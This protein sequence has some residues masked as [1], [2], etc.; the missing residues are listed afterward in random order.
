MRE[1]GM[2][3]RHIPWRRSPKASPEPLWLYLQLDESA[4]DCMRALERP[5]K[6]PPACA[7]K[8]EIILWTMGSAAS[9]PEL[10]CSFCPGPRNEERPADM[11]VQASALIVGAWQRRSCP[12]WRHESP[13]QSPAHRMTHDPFPAGALSTAASIGCRSVPLPPC[14]RLSRLCRSRLPRCSQPAA[15]WT[16]SD[17]AMAQRIPAGTRPDVL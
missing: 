7:L 6:A 10:P 13:G 9:L 17:L 1:S 11:P 16:H 2:C 3:M 15:R 12:N 4:W 14:L 8:S 5:W